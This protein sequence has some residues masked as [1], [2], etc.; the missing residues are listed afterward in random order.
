MEYLYGKD[1]SS[2]I[3]RNYQRLVEAI[4]VEDGTTNLGASI[5][6]TKVNYDEIYNIIDFCRNTNIFPLLGQLENAGKCSE[7]FNDLE[8][9]DDKLIALRNYIKEQYKTD[10]EIP[11]CPA[12][13]SSIHITNTN[14][15]IVDERTGLSCAWFW[16]EDPKMISLGNIR[17]MSAEDITS[18]IIDYRK[19][20]FSDVISIESNLSKNTF[21]GCGGDA[22]TL[23][24]KYIQIANY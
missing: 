15:V 1:R 13:I 5:V 18:K 7:V 6:P 3:L 2:T 16:M 12:T 24:Q 21:G 17:K 9:K 8:L 22:K 11:V 14:N 20:K 10:Y 23:L 4:R 19:S